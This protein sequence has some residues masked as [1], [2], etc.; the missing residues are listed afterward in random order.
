VPSGHQWRPYQWG[1]A[2][3]SHRSRALFI[4]ALVAV[5]MRVSIPQSETWLPYRDPCRSHR[6][7]LGFAVC[8]WIGSIL[9][10][11]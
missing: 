2:S 10:A 8:L 4:G 9:H 11:S 3:I 7:A 6:L 1:P 5:T